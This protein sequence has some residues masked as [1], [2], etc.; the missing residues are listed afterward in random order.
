MPELEYKLATGINQDTLF[1]VKMDTKERMRALYE[2]FNVPNY[3]P[4]PPFIPKSINTDTLVK[5]NVAVPT[6][7]EALES[8]D[9]NVVD[10]ALNHIRQKAAANPM[11]RGVGFDTM[12]KYQEGQNKFTED[13]W[14]KEDNQ[15]MYGFNPYKSVA[16]NEDFLHKQIWDNYSIGGKAWRGV[17]TFAGRTLSKLVTGLVGMV[18]D[19]GSMTWNGLQEVGDLMNINDGTKNNFWNDVSNNW[20]ARQMEHA[21]NYVK[22]SI[23]PTYKALDYDDKGAWAKLFD[24]YT[25]QT[26]FADG[27]GFLLQFAVPGAMFGRAA[28]GG[29]LAR[30]IGVLEEAVVA[31]EATGDAAKIAKAAMT[32][33]RAKN[34]SKLTYAMGAEIPNTTRTGK[35]AGGTAEF[36]T[37][38][39]DVGGMSAHIFNTSMEAVAE[40]KE[41]FNHTVQELMNNGMS[42]EQAIEVASKNAPVQFWL[43]MGI[44]TASNAFQNKLLQKALGNRGFQAGKRMDDGL[45]PVVPTSTTKVGKF[46]S[47][48]KLGNRIKF[49]GGIGVKSSIFEGY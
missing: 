28:Q 13:H 6:V 49:Y 40:T 10:A 4:P 2:G 25:W 35:I 3:Q 45:A 29:K 23:L 26:S 5:G 17:G 33:E 7:S 48:N 34:V 1:N 15:T 47:E 22:E 21:D 8:K 46:F 24:P 37:G 14:W 42:R 9:P 39:K 36:L 18:G 32:L 38:S 43:N 30:S 19:L 44:L 41:G 27:A 16:E 12:V 11:S 31:A 20:L